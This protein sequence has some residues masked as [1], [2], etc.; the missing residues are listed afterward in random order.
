MSSNIQIE[1][2]CTFCGSPFTA[3]TFHT[4]YCSHTCN[5]KHY[6]QLQRQKQMLILPNPSKLPN[7][8]INQDLQF[9]Q[10]LSLSETAVLLG[11]SKRTIQRLITKGQINIGKLGSRIIIKRTELDNLFK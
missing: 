5:Q 8:T 10:F 2:K 4:R 7:S 1:K 11:A 6:K 3:K 9:K